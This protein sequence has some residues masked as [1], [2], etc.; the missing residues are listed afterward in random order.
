MKIAA[1][2]MTS[3]DSIE[4]NLKFIENITIEIL[5]K[6]Q[7]QVIFFP[8]NSLYFRIKADEKIPVIR[9]QDDC[10]LRLERLSTHLN[11]A[12]HLTTT[13]FDEG[14]N[15][16]ASVFI[17]P[18]KKS[19][20]IYKK[21]HLFD[22]LLDNQKPI[23][24]SEVFVHGQQP[25]TFNYGDVIFGSSICYDIRFAELYSVYAKIGIHAL[26]IPA[27]F[28]VPTGAAHWMVLNRA[29]AIESQCYVIAPAQVGEHVSVNNSELKRTTFGHTCIIGPWGDVVQIKELQSGYIVADIIPNVCDKVRTQI[30]MSKHRRL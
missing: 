11:V 29:R 20:L 1:V 14:Q 26:L 27:A 2:Q 7:P 5:H 21:I 28:L 8:E 18:G 16:N 12:L 22:I 10:F 15:W 4:I 6:E 30:P 13:L 17:E 3:V 25:A 9:L 19:K 24:E 23:R